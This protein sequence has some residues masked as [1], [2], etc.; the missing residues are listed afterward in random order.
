MRWAVPLL[1][2]AALCHVLQAG[3]PL[4]DEDRWPWL[5]QLADIVQRHLASGQPAV[6]S[7][8]ALKPAYR[9]LLR[10]GQQPTG[11][12]WSQSSPGDCDRSSGSMG[13]SSSRHAAE[14]G[15]GLSSGDVGFVSRKTPLVATLVGWLAVPCASLQ[16]RSGLCALQIPQSDAYKS[17]PAPFAAIWQVL[18]DPPRTELEQRLLRRSAAGGHFTPGTALLDSQLAAL[19]YE[20][21][22]LLL[23]VRGNP[24]PPAEQVVAAVL[25]RC[26]AKGHS[27]NN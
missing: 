20:E 27:A 13:P 18:L 15:A 14:G 9:Q 17:T 11:S 12:S 2:A 3:T 26:R 10:T 1:N 6:L 8:S 4:C 23:H 5:Q 7:C 24:F 21:A 25:Q 22:E 19:E 16:P